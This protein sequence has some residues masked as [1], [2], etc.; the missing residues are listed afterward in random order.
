MP[1]A[2]ASDGA[3]VRVFTFKA[4]LLSGVA[5]D[6]ELLFDHFRIEWTA[7]HVSATFDT[8]SLR[9]L[10][11]V[12]SGRPAPDTLSARDRRKIE[13]NIA[14][15]VLLSSQHPE[16]RFESSSVLAEGDGFLVRGTLTLAGGRQELS[17]RVCREGAAYTTE[18]VLDQRGFGITPYGAMM[19]AIKL[20]PEVHVRVAVPA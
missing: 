16:A 7:R 10:H 13:Q 14:E 1:I 2:T 4:G 11:A 19:G 12:V 5:H 6:L 18:L 15:D 3:T 8:R 20:K 17:A 9:V